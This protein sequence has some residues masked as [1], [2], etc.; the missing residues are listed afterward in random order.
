V[1][2]Q[3]IEN[4]LQKVI[5]MNPDVE[6]LNYI[7]QNAEMGKDTIKQLLGITEDALFM[8]QLESQL[9]EYNEIYDLANNKLEQAQK[10]AKSIGTLSKLS[11]YIMININT[12]TNKTPSHIAEMMI[13]GSTMGIIEITKNLKEYGNA[14]KEIIDLGNRLLKFEQTNVESMKKFL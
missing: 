4:L 11:A 8:Q 13:R 9:K 6:F 2:Q 3:I 10:E 1:R 12:L 14:D 7:H 5:A